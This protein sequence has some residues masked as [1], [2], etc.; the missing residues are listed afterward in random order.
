MAVGMARTTY[1]RKIAQSDA[2]VT[3]TLSMGISMDHIVSMTIPAL[4]G[5]VWELFGYQ[6]V[7]VGAA[8]I[9][10]INLFMANRINVPIFSNSNKQVQIGQ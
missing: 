4:G 5:L 10:L 3:P 9:A 7:F 2:D 6:Y 1:L 8:V